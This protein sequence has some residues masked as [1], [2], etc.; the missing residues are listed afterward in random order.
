MVL[1]I[2]LLSTSLA[3]IVRPRRRVHLVNRWPEH[4]HSRTVLGTP[5]V[6]PPPSGNLA[7]VHWHRARTLHRRDRP[8]MGRRRRAAL[9][10]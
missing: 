3:C 9:L 4:R 10:L 7:G 2:L 8:R 6:L 1:P 5:E